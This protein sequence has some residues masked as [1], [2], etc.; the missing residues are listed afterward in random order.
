[1]IF[2]H[3]QTSSTSTSK[4]HF[5][6][7]G[8]CDGL[9]CGVEDLGAHGHGIQDVPVA[10][11]TAYPPASVLMKVRPWFCDKMPQ[12]CSQQHFFS[13]SVHLIVKVSNA[14][15]KT[16]KMDRIDVWCLILGKISSKMRC[17]KL[18]GRTSDEMTVQFVVAKDLNLGTTI[19]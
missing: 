13:Q 19:I 15:K 2:R 12:W 4:Q 9:G 1:M 11:T 5:L 10:M 3:L 8:N 7:Q 14:E 16:W 18:A 6:K 17:K